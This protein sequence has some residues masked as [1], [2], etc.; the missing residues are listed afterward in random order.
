MLKNIHSTRSQ[1]SKFECSPLT[2]RPGLAVKGLHPNKIEHYF[3][4]T[5]VPDTDQTVSHA[6][7]LKNQK[8]T[9]TIVLCCRWVGN[10]KINGCF[11]KK[12]GHSRPLFLYFRLF[13]RQLTVNKFSIKIA[14]DS[15]LTQ[16]LWYWKRPL[17]QLRHNHYPN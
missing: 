13:Y 1:T 14:N 15:I 10:E 16:V 8:Q 17:C 4:S 6:V 5:Q 9:S 12:M 7:Y 2:A 3:F 11:F